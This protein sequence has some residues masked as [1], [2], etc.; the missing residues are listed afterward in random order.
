MA[1]SY[2]C[3]EQ[4]FHASIFNFAWSLFSSWAP[5]HKA[6]WRGS[7]AEDAHWKFFVRISAVGNKTRRARFSQPAGRSDFAHSSQEKRQRNK[8]IQVESIFHCPVRRWWHSQ[9]TRSAAF[10]MVRPNL[11]SR[12]TKNARAQL[13]GNAKEIIAPPTEKNK[14]LERARSQMSV[15]HHFWSTYLTNAR[16]DATQECPLHLRKGAKY[17]PLK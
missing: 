7:G 14:R 5:C 2:Q 16:A 10:F 4:D 8:T 9:K 15:G 1:E 3:P 17:K 11:S 12:N 6:L 13:W